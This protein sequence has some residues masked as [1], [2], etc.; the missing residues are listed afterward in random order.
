MRKAGCGPPFSF[1]GPVV[2]ASG[3][4]RMMA[5]FRYLETTQGDTM[6]VAS[7]LTRMI[8]PILIIV[9]AAGCSAASSKRDSAA[10]DFSEDPTTLTSADVYKDPD[11]MICRR[12]RPTGSRISEKVCMTASQWYNAS[13]AARRT[14][15]EAQ[16]SARGPDAL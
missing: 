5:S 16:R 14:L 9:F 13:E 2:P 7:K 8:G 3:F 1:W 11:R 10:G 12:E 15:D 6:Y 4:A